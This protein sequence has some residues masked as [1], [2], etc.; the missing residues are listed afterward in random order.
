MH[1][2]I[3]QVEIIIITSPPPVVCRALKALEDLDV[4]RSRTTDHPFQCQVL[5]VVLVSAYVANQLAGLE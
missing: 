1:N 2:L 3:I 4:K 5:E